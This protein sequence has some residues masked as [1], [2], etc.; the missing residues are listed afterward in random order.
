MS[1]WAENT[2]EH[3]C[4]SCGHLVARSSAEIVPEECSQCGY[5]DAERVAEF[6]LDESNDED[7]DDE[8]GFDCPA[9]SDGCPLAGTEECDWDCPHS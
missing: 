3:W 1:A 5:P 4:M 7:V 8:P 2:D 9:S 6:H